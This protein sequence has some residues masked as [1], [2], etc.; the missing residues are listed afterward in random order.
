MLTLTMCSTTGRGDAAKRALAGMSSG[1]PASPARRK[2]PLASG[3]ALSRSSP[4]GM[5]HP[6]EPVFRGPSAIFMG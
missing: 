2:A 3:M 1:P 6:A 5:S 4:T